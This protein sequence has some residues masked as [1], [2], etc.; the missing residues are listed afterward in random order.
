YD[1]WVVEV[2][3]EIARQCVSLCDLL[4]GTRARRG[5]L[6]GAVEVARRRIQLQPLE[7]VG[8]R[9]LMLLQAGLGDRAGAVSTYHHCASVL[10]RELG[11]VPDPETQQACQRLTAR[12]DQGGEK[13]PA[14]EAALGRSGP[15]AARIV[16]RSQELGVLQDL[17]RAAAAGSRGLA[18]VRG[19]AGVGKTRLVTEVAERALQH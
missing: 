12:A 14:V 10:E 6:P 17:W 5:D 18:V 15:V 13:P 8:Y 7:E 2:R 9:T 1:G 11:V 19:G 3:S 16:G 4:A